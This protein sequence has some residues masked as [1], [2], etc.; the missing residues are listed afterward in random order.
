[1]PRIACLLV[2]DFALAALRRAEP[3]LC[4]QPLV[5]VDRDDPRA[6]LTAVSAEARALGI[7]SGLS[8]AQARAISSTLAVRRP[9]RE[10]LAAAEE[11]L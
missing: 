2:P 1:M 9:S 11:A 4:G 8:A 6:P 7:R 3:E 10:M 5:A